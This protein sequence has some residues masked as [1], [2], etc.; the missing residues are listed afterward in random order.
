MASEQKEV[1]FFENPFKWAFSKGR[2]RWTVIILG[3][4]ALVL[5]AS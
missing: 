1:G 5:A 4:L 2:A 3:S